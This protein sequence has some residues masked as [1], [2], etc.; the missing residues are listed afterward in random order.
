MQEGF[1]FS[2]NVR[3]E[4]TVQIK[5]NAF[6][7][8][9]IP[10]ILGSVGLTTAILS[11]VSVKNYS[12][13]QKEFEQTTDFVQQKDL[14]DQGKGELIKSLVFSGVSLATISSA[15]ILYLKKNKQPEKKNDISLTPA[16]DHELTGVLLT[17]RF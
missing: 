16:L 13:L 17:F 1:P 5:S 7:K 6:V 12:D 11:G 14:N 3:G 10:V 4:K 2:Y 9:G 15:I 8:K